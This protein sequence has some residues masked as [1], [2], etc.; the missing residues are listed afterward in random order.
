MFGHEYLWNETVNVLDF[1]SED[2]YQGKILSK[3][4]TV[5]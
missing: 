3:T 5:G 1:F 2:I 4:A